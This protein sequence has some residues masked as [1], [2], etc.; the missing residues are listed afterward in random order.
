MGGWVGGWVT[1][2]AAGDEEG[3]EAFSSSIPSSSSS[4]GGDE[5]VALFSLFFNRKGKLLYF[6]LSLA[7]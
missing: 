1:L 2:L 5:G 3:R 4:F 7:D 6:L